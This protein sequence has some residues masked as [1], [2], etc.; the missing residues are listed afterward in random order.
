MIK[1][2][3]TKLNDKTMKNLTSEE[4]LLGMEEREIKREFEMLSERIARHERL[5]NEAVDLWSERW[6]EV[7]KQYILDDLQFLRIIKFP[8][9]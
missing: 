4:T 1:I 5:K 7:K 3:Y 6:F 2:I 8:N 9:D